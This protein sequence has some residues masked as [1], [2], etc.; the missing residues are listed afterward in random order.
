MCQHLSS[1]LCVTSCV[2]IG[3]MLQLWR[4]RA[5]SSKM[6]KE[7]MTMV[8]QSPSPLTACGRSHMPLL[9]HAGASQYSH[10]EAT[11]VSIDTDAIMLLLLGL[12]AENIAQALS[13]CLHDPQVYC[14]ICWLRLQRTSSLLSLPRLSQQ[15]LISVVFH[16]LSWCP[17]AMR[18]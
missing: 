15:V 7:G 16:L 8:V 12:F 9:R 4:D 1:R 13:V 11:A 17:S 10:A 3:P 18:C 6:P 14:A 2:A 5:H